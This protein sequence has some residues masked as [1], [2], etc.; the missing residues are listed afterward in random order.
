MRRTTWMG[1]ALAAALFAAPSVADAAPGSIVF[2]AP[3]K[4]AAYGEIGYSGIPRL[5]YMTPVGPRLA[6]SGEFIL[7]I[8]AFN[9]LGAGVPGTVTLAGG[10]P[11]KV[12]LMESKELIV[13][14]GLT[15]GIGVTFPR[16]GADA[17]FALLLHSELN[18]GFRV[19]RQMIV[20]GSV[21]IPMTVTIGNFSGVLIPILFG[22]AVEFELTPEWSLT[23]E[24]KMGP[25]IA[26]GDFFGS[27][28]FGFKFQVGAAYSF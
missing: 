8:G 28:T 16:F 3:K 9:S 21:D 17:Q 26:A 2:G 1:L 25:H 14:L 23:G 15:P 13:G 5:G 11:V 24:L 6:I 18:V 4:Q 10:L 22:P 12:L 20:G 7:D 27:T 19:D